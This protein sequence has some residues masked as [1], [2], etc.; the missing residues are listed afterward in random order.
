MKVLGRGSEAGVAEP[1]RRG[2]DAQPSPTGQFEPTMGANAPR[3]RSRLPAMGAGGHEKGPVPKSAGARQ[4][5][6]ERVVSA[7]G[8]PPGPPG[9][10]LALRRHFFRWAQAGARRGRNWGRLPAQPTS[11]RAFGA[12][13]ATSAARRVGCAYISMSPRNGGSAP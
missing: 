6:P 12:P 8:G 11:E 4:H 13:L 5:G 10:R 9:P 3:G 2:A 1:A 7:R